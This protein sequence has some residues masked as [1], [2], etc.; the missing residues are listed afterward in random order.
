MYEMFFSQA[1]V[2]PRAGHAKSPRLRHSVQSMYMLCSYISDFK[3]IY[4]NIL[5]I[6]YI[7]VYV[8]SFKFYTIS[9][10]KN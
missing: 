8:S 7:F 9:R 6:F 3:N 5:S 10:D 2:F 1:H 4:L